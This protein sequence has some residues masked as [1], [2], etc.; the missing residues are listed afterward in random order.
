[1]KHNKFLIVY[2]AIFLIK[3]FSNICMF[4]N[5]GLC[6]T[7]T[8]CVAIFTLSIR[9]RVRGFF[10]NLWPTVSGNGSLL[11]LA[12]PA[13]VLIY[14]DIITSYQVDSDLFLISGTCLCLLINTYSHT[15]Y[16][17]AAITGILYCAGALWLAICSSITIC[18]L[19]AICAT[20][21]IYILLISLNFS[22]ERDNKYNRIYAV[23]VLLVADYFILSSTAGIEW[24]GIELLRIVASIEAS[25]VIYFANCGVSVSLLAISLY[26]ANMI[27]RRQRKMLIPEIIF[28]YVILGYLAI[29]KWNYA[30]CIVYV[31][32]LTF[33][34]S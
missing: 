13:L 7:G 20:S 14:F 26:V 17:K 10:N 3:C 19:I 15:K 28:S 23:V 18:G 32:V 25:P 22:N 24:M 6:I 8:L 5:I 31:I 21:L 2:I 34:F 12:V 16:S 27:R 9:W 4:S 33:L 29:E 30:S 1:M 11:Y